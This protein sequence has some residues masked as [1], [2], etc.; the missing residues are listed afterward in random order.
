[1]TLEELTENFA[2][3]GI[4]SFAED[5][6]LLRADVSLPSCTATVYLHGAHLTHWQPAGQA[7]VLWL[8]P[9]SEFAPGKAIRGGVP[10]CWPWFATDT[11]NHDSGKPGPNHGFVRTQAWELGFAALAGQALHLT[12]TLAPNDLSR[13]FGFSNFRLA[14]E[15]VLAE[16]LT[17]RL[18][19]ANTGSEPLAFEEALHTYFAADPREAALHGLES[20]TFLDKTDGFQQKTGPADA[21]HL[22]RTTDRV[23]PGATGTVLIA[24][25]T[26]T[27]AVEKRNSRT[28]VVWNPYPEGL[29]GVHDMPADAW[30]HFLCVETANTG[31]DRIT[32]APGEAHTMEARI[33]AKPDGRKT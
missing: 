20:A 1:M 9:T 22:D 11:G 27:V 17:L 18:S 15:L 30:E 33:Q 10:V 8:S 13:R 28:T 23:Y 21:L 29:K 4:L 6:G 19:V 26:R 31:T 5:H 3:P 32:L 14:Y 16:T 2:L 24:E 25:R 12:F 7:P